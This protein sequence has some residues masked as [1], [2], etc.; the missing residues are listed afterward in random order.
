MAGPATTAYGWLVDA[1]RHGVFSPGSRLP[2]ER[3]L[4]E[5]VGVS[6]STL[7]HALSRLADEGAVTRFAQRGW[8]VTRQVVGEP[9]SV[10]QSF[11]EMARARGLRPTSRI[12]HQRTRQSTIAEATRL[13]IAPSA[14][15]LEIRRL[16]AMDDVPVCIDSSVLIAAKVGPL[17]DADLTDRSLYEA[18]A[19]DCDI[20][21]A[22]SSYAV[23]AAAA[24]ADIASLLDLDPGAPVL[25]GEET[26]YAT[27]GTPI[28]FGLATYRGDAYRFE[29]DLY[30]RLS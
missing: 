29:A 16:R 24:D 12:L 26:T 20:A 13:H 2:G 18:L 28:L 27:D 3:E 19:S 4:A 25:V 22:R 5:R 11:S 23:Q 1:L 14:R 15:V 30:R 8:F 17:I 10:L 21:V 6:R 9:P 7:R